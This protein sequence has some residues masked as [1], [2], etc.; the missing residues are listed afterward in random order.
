MLLRIYNKTSQTVVVNEQ[1]GSI[2]GNSQRQYPLRI[3]QLEQ[4]RASL[5]KLEQKGIIAWSVAEDAN[6]D[7][8]AEGSVISLLSKPTFNISYVVGNA[9]AGDTQKDCD[10]LDPGDGS[11]IAYALTL[12]RGLGNIAIRN[13]LY[14]FSLGTVGINDQPLTIPSDIVVMGA[15]PATI[16]RARTDG[17]SQGVF[18]LSA[19]ATLTRMLCV[20]AQPTVPTGGTTALISVGG[21]DCEISF[22]IASIN[23]NDGDSLLSAVQIQPSA[24]CHV[25]NNVLTNFNSNTLGGFSNGVVDIA[26]SQSIVSGNTITAAAGNYCV[27]IQGASNY[28]YVAGNILNANGGAQIFVFPGTVGNVTAPNVLI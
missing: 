17:H 4:A 7:D 3:E 1:I 18:L 21:N 25:I 8:R 9:L 26:S 11:G 10:I 19:R 12:P 27:S 16:V 22:M 28:N 24:R 6:E 15:G 14:D 2:E 13:G 23:P 20:A 5:V